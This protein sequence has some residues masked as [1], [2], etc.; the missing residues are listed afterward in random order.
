[1]VTIPDLGWL[2][3]LVLTAVS[4]PL[5]LY[6]V[7]RKTNQDSLINTANR[8]VFISI[9]LQGLALVFFLLRVREGSYSSLDA[10]GLYATSLPASPLICSSSWRTMASLCCHASHSPAA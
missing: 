9:L 10:E 1:M 8:A 2:M 4:V 7:W 5:V 3:V 6:L